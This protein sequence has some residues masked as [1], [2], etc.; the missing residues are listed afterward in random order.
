MTSCAAIIVA[1][2]RGAR[3]GGA[4]PKQYADLGGIPLVRY[5]LTALVNHTAI[6]TVVPVI[7]PDDNEM[8]E[9]AAAGLDIAPPVSGGT[10]RQE[11]VRRGLEALADNPPATVLIHDGARPKLGDALIDRVINALSDPSIAGAIPVLPVPDTL[12]RIDDQGCIT[13]TV[14][15][16]NV[17]RAQTPQGFA[18]APLLEAHRAAAADSMTDDA[19]VL[20]RAGYKVATVPGDPGNIKVT[21]N[22]DLVRVAALL[23]ETRTGSGFDV[24]RFGPG[25]GLMLGG[26]AIAF[27][28]G[29]IGHSDADVVLHAATDAIL[30]A[31][32]DGDIGVHFPPSDPSFKDSPS[33]VFL[34][35]AMDRLKRRLGALL[36]LDLTVICERPKLA[37]HREKM[38]KRISEI[39]GVSLSRI[40]IKATTTE[41]LGFTGRGEGIACQA[42]ATVQLVP[43]S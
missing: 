9:T 5:A 28:Q 15:R 24:H 35:F 4:F 21:D 16:T 7:H 17:V 36:H 42:Q 1:A 22:S 2:G 32:A 12:K 25:N 31:M 13:E 40:S 3:F 43:M 23:S 11:S 6:G 10:T 39:T 38:R 41:G 26:V 27:D 19:A 20:E 37:P 14:S 33:D 8:F 29:L 18:F 30:G 34:A